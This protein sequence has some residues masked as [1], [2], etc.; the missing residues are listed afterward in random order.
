MADDRIDDVKEELRKFVVSNYLKG[1]KGYKL[2]DDDSFLK[3]AI[4]DSIGVIELTAFIQK[5]YKVR[6]R[7]SEIVPEN[8]DTLNNL[9]KY[10]VLKLKEAA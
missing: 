1:S 3:K 2:S 9:E 6:V 10:I 4:L 7:V 5:K 8:F